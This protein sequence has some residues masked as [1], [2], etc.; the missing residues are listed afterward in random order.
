PSSRAALYRATAPASE[1]WSVSETADISS[2]AARLARS[3]IR[4]APSRIEYSE[5][6][7]RWTKGASGTGGRSEPPRPTTS[8]RAVVRHSGGAWAPPRP[9]RSRRHA[10][11][12]GRGD[13][14][15]RAP[16]RLARRQRRR[17]AVLVLG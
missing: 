3:G 15:R 10:A 5:W 4:Q 6:T 17:V 13:R 16:S 12:R 2:S 1:P 11:P 14:G 7:W 9:P 8:A